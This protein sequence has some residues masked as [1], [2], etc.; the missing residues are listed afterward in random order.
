VKFFGATSGSYMLW[1]ESTDDLILG[2]AAKLGIGTTA[3]AKLVHIVGAA[4]NALLEGLQLDNTDHAS[5]ETGQAIAINMRL[6]KAGT[7]RDAGRIT[8]GKDDD[9]DDAGASDSHLTFKTNLS[10]TL[11]E[12]MR[13]TSAGNVGI[14]TTAPEGNLHIYG[15]SAGTISYQAEADNLIIESSGETGIS[16]ACPDANNTYIYF[17]NASDDIGAGMFWDYNGDTNGM[18]TISTEKANAQMRFRIA[19]GTEAVRINASGQVGIGTTAPAHMLVAKGAAGTSPAFEMINSDT[20]DSDTGRETSI[21]FSGF[22]SGGEAM[23]NAQIGGHHDGSADDD[24]GMLL[25]ATNDGTGHTEAMRITSTGFV[26]IG[27]TAPTAKLVVNVSG[28]T[29]CAS[30]NQSGTGASLN[31]YA[32]TSNKEQF[33]MGG[34][35]Y[36]SYQGL[37]TSAHFWRTNTTIRGHRFYTNQATKSAGVQVTNGATGWSS[38]SDGRKKK[39]WIL[40]ENAVD[41]I[42]T[43]TKIGTY[44]QINPVTK[45]YDVLDKDGNPVRNVGVVSQEVEPFLPEAVHKEIDP[46]IDS[47]TEYHWMDYHALGVLA[48]KAIQELSAEN[49]ALKARVTTLEG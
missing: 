44:H 3:P 21:R 35:G 13:I 36:A 47:D 9:W 11:T 43:L 33:T 18:F 25:F 40:F 2:G 7:M 46:N 1:D 42:N 17:C 34:G 19:D 41:K 37:D 29:S 28:G 45:E 38:I 27:S 20:E 4:D 16:L 24:K 10:D 26:G 12:H 14:G 8:V 6:S 32:A 22:R 49:T 48:I 39:D 15:G 31:L 5:T 30:F 23:I